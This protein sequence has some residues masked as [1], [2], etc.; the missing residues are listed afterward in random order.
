MG[1]TDG[2][3]EPE[4]TIGTPVWM[5]HRRCRDVDPA[6]FYPDGA[7]GVQEAKRFCHG[8]SVEDLCLEYAMDTGEK[9]GVWGGTS[10]RE[11]RRLRKTWH[12]RE[13]A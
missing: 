12:L 9:F 11:R 3:N 7:S 6:L 4:P 5:R 8:C 10:E 1:L 2:L 13:T